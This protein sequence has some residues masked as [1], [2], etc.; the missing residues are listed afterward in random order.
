M[1]NSR[2]TMWAG[3]LLG[4]AALG[5]GLTRSAQAAPGP[6]AGVDCSA[7]CTLTAGYGSYTLPGGTLT[8][9]GYT[10]DGSAP[11]QPGGPVLLTTVGTSTSRN[12]QELAVGRGAR[13]VISMRTLS[14]TAAHAN[15]EV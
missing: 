6:V 13:E 3:I 11:T 14:C 8:V 10:S 2:Y 1:H 4:L 9:Y 12:R 7:G 15:R 5:F